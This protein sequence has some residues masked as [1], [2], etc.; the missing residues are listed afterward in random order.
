VKQ[1]ELY[2][3]ARSVLPLVDIK[4]KIGQ[5]SILKHSKYWTSRAQNSKPRSKSTSYNDESQESQTMNGNLI[6]NRNSAETS[7]LRITN[8]DW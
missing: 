5:K 2:F 8:T 6:R 4:C 7:K 1:G 3:L